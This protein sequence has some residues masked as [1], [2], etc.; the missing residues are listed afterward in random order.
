M[1]RLLTFPTHTG[2]K[3]RTCRRYAGVMHQRAA[4]K[5]APARVVGAEGSTSEEHAQDGL[6][7][8]GVVVVLAPPAARPRSLPSSAVAPSLVTDGRR[9]D[10][11]RF[12]AF[13]RSIG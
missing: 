7:C 4:T 9:S 8:S 6:R 1:E 5:L 3:R 2:R 13:G 11:G 10:G 12:L